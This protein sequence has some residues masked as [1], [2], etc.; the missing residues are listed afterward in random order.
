MEKSLEILSISLRT[1]LGVLREALD[2]FTHKEPLLE[3]R[4]ILA[5]QLWA[6]RRDAVYTLLASTDLCK[7][8]HVLVEAGDVIP[9]DGEVIEGTALVDEAAATGGREPVI[10]AKGDGWTSV[11]GGTRVLS[12]WLVIRITADPG[13]QGSQSMARCLQ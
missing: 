3:P 2:M 8:D 1:S 9:G 11:M 13:G 5:K 6:P 12:D 10:R 4:T 7:G